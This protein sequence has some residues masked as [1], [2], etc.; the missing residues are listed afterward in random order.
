MNQFKVA[1]NGQRS[2]FFFSATSND[3]KR[4]PA[5]LACAHNGGSYERD[6]STEISSKRSRSFR[7]VIS[8][9]CTPL[10]EEWRLSSVP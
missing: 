9:G 7:R 3:V 1:L 4:E 10:L 8:E 2:F 6:T 5:S